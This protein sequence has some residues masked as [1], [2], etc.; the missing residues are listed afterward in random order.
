MEL[1]EQKVNPID[2]LI[3]LSPKKKQSKTPIAK[4]RFGNYFSEF[5]YNELEEKLKEYKSSVVL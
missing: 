2:K 3:R 5:E 4:I 1:Y